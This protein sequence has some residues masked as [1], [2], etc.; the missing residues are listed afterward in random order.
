M[1]W[2][3]RRPWT[4]SMASS[5]AHR[6]SAPATQSTLWDTGLVGRDGTES[7]VYQRL[8]AVRASLAR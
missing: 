1:P 4:A 6:Y 3:P 2:R 5:S 7:L 8:R